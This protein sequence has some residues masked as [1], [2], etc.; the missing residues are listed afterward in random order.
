MTAE[1]L[2]Y[3]ILNV[4]KPPVDMTVSEW[5]DENR[6]LSSANA[7]P[8]RW[9]TQ[10]F[11][12]LREIMDSCSANSEVSEVIFMKAA[13]IGGT[14]CLNN[15]IG[16]YIDK[17]PCSIMMVQPT[18]EMAKDYSKQRIAPMI[19][20][21]ESLKNKIKPAKSRDG[22][23]TILLKEFPGG[24]LAMSGSNSAAGL[25]SKPIAILLPDEIDAYPEDV[26]GEGDPLNLAK[27]RTR[28]FR[29]KKIIAVSTPTIKGASRIEDAFESTD[30]RRYFVPCPHCGHKHTLDWDNFIFD[31]DETGRRAVD[32]YMVCPKCGC[33]IDESFKTVMLESGEWRPTV[34]ENIMPYKRGY[35]LSALYSPLG[36][37][38]WLEIANLWIEAQS[39][40]RKLK[41]F[42]NTV[43]GQT[44][45]EEGEKIDESDLE[46]RRHH[47][48]AELPDGVL[49]LTAS[50]DVQ[51]DRLECEIVG[52]G[53]GK[54]SWGIYYKQFHGDL[55]ELESS[56]SS[57]PSPWQQLDV[58]LQREWKFADGGGLL[59][60][61]C[62]VDSG[63]HFTQEVYKF[64][65]KREHRRIYAVKGRGGLG[66][67]F[68]S[69]LSRNNKQKAALFHVGVDGGKET[70]FSR[71]KIS[72]EGPGYCHFPTNKDAG[73]DAMYFKGL[74]SEKKETKFIKGKRH[75]YW[76]KL[77]QSIKN[78]PLDL[79]NYGMAALEILNPNFEALKETLEARKTKHYQPVRPRGRQIS[80][81]ISL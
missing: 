31:K 21:C 61:G 48:D 33:K 44:W 59:I 63:G 68:L 43:L 14:E 16:Y 23:N 19:N 56:D 34:P 20:E 60:S 78:E 35:H 75:Y 65:K 7:E 53:E 27:A 11:P 30:Q 45:E 77:S 46:K 2:I 72:H 41:T 1:E 28:T 3:G 6:V 38:S 50:V 73:Y 26:D 71:L 62:C 79:R 12:F 22:N 49:I 69:K 40:T 81:G 54:E 4:L 5:A 18:V 80:R 66:V 47:Y 52:W 51:D 17:E 10:R 42:V 32:A 13:Q 9:R 36:F 58:F 8:G 24:F 25:R 74:L 64:T 15:V 55:S 76:K 29:K 57:R 70:I 67:P 37:L 39:D